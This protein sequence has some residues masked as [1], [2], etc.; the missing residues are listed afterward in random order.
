[1][2]KEIIVVEG[3]DD[4]AAVKRAVEAEV[5]SV[6]GFGITGETF[7]LLKEAS[8]KKGIIVLTDPDHAGE[9][10]R[11]R[12]E[13]AVGKDVRHAYIMRE[14]GLKKGNVGVENASPEAIREAL[15]RAHATIEEKREEFTME[16]L[17]RAGLTGRS[18]SANRRKI[19]GKTLRIGF[20][21]TGTMLKRL[22]SYGVLREEFEKA[23]EDLKGEIWVIQQEQQLIDIILNSLNP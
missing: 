9:S 15:N 5:I 1:M 4:E 7:K 6:H 23:I 22:N 19:I 8:R 11:R 18:D 20:A 21:N 16:D 3:K 17:L 13:E 10:I 14:E 12:I 2:I